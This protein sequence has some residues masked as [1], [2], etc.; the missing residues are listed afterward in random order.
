[1]R[2][3]LLLALLTLA[4]VACGRTG[5]QA[6]PDAVPKSASDTTV[7]GN[8]NRAVAPVTIQALLALLPAPFDWQQEKPNG[9]RMTT[10]MAYSDASVRLM[11]GDATVTAKIT[12]TALN[13]ALVAP[14]ATALAGDFARETDHGY[15]KSVAI[16]DARGVERWDSATRTGNL[17]VVV[18]RRFI[19][20]ID[21]S[22]I[23]GP[24][25]LH[26][27]LEKID[28]KKLADLK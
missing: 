27:I 10:P 14:F 23:E 1:M 20:E 28:L 2:P 24:K 26:D 19:V 11:K 12:D 6:A 25:I 3:A 18:A 22:T 15:E 9:E 21:G 13:A 17:A 5:D 8:S 16:G 7:G 4:T